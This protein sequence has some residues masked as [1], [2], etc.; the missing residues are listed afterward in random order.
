MLLVVFLLK[1][2]WPFGTI[3][4]TSG[5]MAQGTLPIVYHIYDWLHG[6]K[7]LLF[8]WYSGLGISVA[9]SYSVT[10]FDLLLYFFKRENLIY[11]LSVLVWVRS[12]A[13]AFTARLSFEKMFPKAPSIWKILFSVSYALSGYAMTY[14]TN[15]SWLDFVILFPLLLWGLKRLLDENKPIL[16]T[17]CYAIALYLSFYQGYMISLA[18]FFL[19]GLYL[20]TA[21][22]KKQAPQ[23]TALLGISSV[24]GALLSCFHMVPSALLSLTSQRFSNNINDAASEG[25]IL[26]ILRETSLYV[27]WEKV[28]LVMGLEFA[29]AF[30]LLFFLRKLFRKQ[31]KQA[32]FIG[33]SVFLMFSQVVLENANLFWHGGKYVQFPMRFFYT[34]VFFLLCLALRYLEQYGETFRPFTANV[35]KTIDRF[36]IF[37]LSAAFLGTLIYLNIVPMKSNLKTACW[38]VVFTLGLV[39]ALMSTQQ[40]KLFTRVLCTVLVLAECTGIAYY[41]IANFSLKTNRQ[42]TY[43]SESY[44]KYCAEASEMDLSTSTLGRIKNPDT[45][46][47]TNYPFIT[48]TQALSNWTH[49]I[50]STVQKAAFALGYSKQYTRLLDSGGTIF[51]DSLLGIEKAVSRNSY[52]KTSGYTLLEKTENFS[53]YKN[54]YALPLGLTADKSIETDLTVCEKDVELA[55]KRFDTQNQLYRMFTQSDDN[56]IAYTDTSGKTTER[57]ELKQSNDETVIFIYTAGKNEILYLNACDFWSTENTHIK[58]NGQSINVPYYKHTGIGLYPSDAVNGILDL[59]SFNAGE[60]V[61]V[62]ISRSAQFNL[63]KKTVQLGYLS[64]D[65]MQAL[66][67]SSVQISNLSKGKT[68]LAFDYNNT[69]SEANYLFIPISY[70]SGW[71]ATVNGEKATVTKA[72]G[73][74]LAV[75]LPNGSG[76][77]TLRHRTPGLALGLALSAVGLLGFALL[78][79]WKK[80]EFRINRTV[81][82]IL[83][84]LFLLAFF[85]AFLII[86][87]ASL[88]FYAKDILYRILH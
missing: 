23:R 64:L 51:T 42:T 76:Q 15:L 45:S 47:N 12:I 1:R 77:V 14:Y 17:V 18:V 21:V 7:A 5:D 70:D 58:V 26:H 33:G 25:M 20:L 73:A 41:G 79:L 52:Y 6:D 65:K 54:D 50:P 71:E 32:V 44:V 80:R 67:A 37:V 11:A 49:F 61:E 8:D 69:N 35:P 74:Y 28:P 75:E 4:V 85:G 60:T 81:S 87:G 55:K 36:L 38:I 62:E 3:N 39:V 24:V 63:T 88:A 84:V 57:I 30:A 13:A 43:Q 40:S 86:Y 29:A 53:T 22:P 19:G 83:F 27:M 56:L 10:P 34:S 46:L 66:S 72:L 9:A 48:Q 78:M 82:I 68:S 31:F 59:G 16:Y 2:I